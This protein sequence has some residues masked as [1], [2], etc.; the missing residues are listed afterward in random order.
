MAKWLWYSIKKNDLSHRFQG[1]GMI[2]KVGC[3]FLSLGFVLVLAPGLFADFTT[4]AVNISN[5]AADSLYPKVA[6]LPGTDCVFVAWVEISGD[7][8]L[9]YF[10]RSIDGGATWSA[11]L[12]LTLAGQIRGHSGSPSADYLYDFYTFSMAVQDPYIHIVYQWRLNES[13]DF[14][15]L[16]AR[17]SDLGATAENWEF[18]VLTD[19]WSDT[20][21]PDVAVR[22]EHVHVAYEDSWPGNEEIMYKR[23]TG[24]G[25]GA[26][27]LTRRLTFSSTYSC[28]PRIAVSS[29][30]E[31][32]NVVYE[33]DVSGG[34]NI[35]Y[36]NI[37]S[38]GAGTFGTYQLTFSTFGN[39]FPDVATSA[40][41]VPDDQ[42][43]YIVYKTAYPGNNEIMYK[44][45]D[46]YGQPGFSVYTARLTYSIDSS[47]G[48]TVG[49]DDVNKIIHVS[50]YDFWP[51][52]N[53]VMHKK[54]E[55]F[56]GAGFATQRVSWGTGDSSHPTVAAVDT[57]A[58]VAWAD[59][60]T[61]NYEILV[62][63]GS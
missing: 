32:V 34:F 23:V 52:N 62:K 59:N 50:Y 41:T 60:T 30:G 54:F 57:G 51:G 1:G 15:I 33:D 63:K 17:S 4:P 16:Y 42:Y 13:E 11:P 14:E 27:D 37:G 19:S 58:Y 29:T 40:G 48:A 24:Y 9:L 56:G 43:V 38:Y 45:L 36:K 49:F 7:D 2:G 8:D 10:S 5:S 26:V 18:R 46:N 3:L 61:G 25:A 21:R 47:A 44:R 12:P 22:G 55:N 6:G 28:F 35:L 20:I 39:D 53:D 31:I